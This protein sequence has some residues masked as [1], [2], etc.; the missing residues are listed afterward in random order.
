MTRSMRTNLSIATAGVV[1]LIL[2]AG[3]ILADPS[4]A[5]SRPTAVEGQARAATSRAQTTET[6]PAP[7]EGLE[8]AP[9]APGAK[10]APE[11]TTY[12]EQTMA[13]LGDWWRDEAMKLQTEVTRIHLEGD[14]AD[15]EARMRKLLEAFKARTEAQ[16]A[17]LGTDRAR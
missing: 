7:G 17:G 11:R 15:Q 3:W 6:S 16:A 14:A 1:V 13:Q 9:F 2:A 5:D 12:D 4:D 8:T 10:E